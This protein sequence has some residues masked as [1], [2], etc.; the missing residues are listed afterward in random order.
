MTSYLNKETSI[1]SSIV[2][3]YINNKKKSKIK[4]FNFCTKNFD[5]PF[6]V[7]DLNSSLKQYNN[8]S[9]LNLVLWFINYYEEISI[10]RDG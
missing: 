5:A 3:R 7:F 8:D 9:K 2:L 4:F 1:K 6:S 10:N